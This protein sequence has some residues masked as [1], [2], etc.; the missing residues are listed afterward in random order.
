M[1]RLRILEV[2]VPFAVVWVK[3]ELSRI[4]HRAHNRKGW[5]VFE[6]EQPK[7]GPMGTQAARVAARESAEGSPSG[8]RSAGVN[9]LTLPSGS[10]RVK[11]HRG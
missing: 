10:E 8:A 11:G 7:V 9:E 5:G 4:D 1:R 6:K 2:R 3:L